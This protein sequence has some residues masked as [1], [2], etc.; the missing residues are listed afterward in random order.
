MRSNE[1]TVQ[2]IKDYETKDHIIKWIKQLKCDIADIDVT[3]PEYDYN[4]AMEAV[5]KLE[6]YLAKLE[7]G[8]Y[9][10]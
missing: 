3:S 1:Y 6:L 5:I 10:E 4:Q 8:D 2:D 9:R 7:S